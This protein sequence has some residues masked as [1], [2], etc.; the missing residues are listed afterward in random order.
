MQK[1]ALTSKE[2]GSGPPIPQTPKGS[3]ADPKGIKKVKKIDTTDLWTTKLLDHVI[4]PQDP[5][6]PVTDP[7][8]LAVLERFMAVE[9]KKLP[10]LV[11]TL[12]DEVRIRI[13]AWD[14]DRVRV[15]VRITG[16]SGE[17]N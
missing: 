14:R 5:A 11:E 13:R 17:F 6:G 4:L 10:A 15:R 9:D 12:I 2:R 8:P 7:T 1:R 16:L 3:K